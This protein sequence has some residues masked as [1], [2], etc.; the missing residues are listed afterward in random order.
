MNHSAANFGGPSE[1]GI[2]M[3]SEYVFLGDSLPGIQKLF[4]IPVYVGLHF[5]NFQCS[6]LLL[7]AVK[8]SFTSDFSDRI[9]CLLYML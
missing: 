9:M 6:L 3:T 8:G 4:L 1:V 7:V 2:F 5:Q